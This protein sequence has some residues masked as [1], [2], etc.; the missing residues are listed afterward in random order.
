VGW[1]WK[2][3]RAHAIDFKQRRL[4]TMYL[5]DRERATWHKQ[6]YAQPHPALL[7]HAHLPFTLSSLV[8]MPVC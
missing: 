4:I 3:K 5:R 1:A 8:S 2:S 6:Q 7:V